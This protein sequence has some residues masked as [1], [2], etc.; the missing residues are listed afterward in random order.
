MFLPRKMRIRVIIEPAAFQKI[1]GFMFQCSVDDQT[2][3]YCSMLLVVHYDEEYRFHDS[4]VFPV[5]CC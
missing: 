4:Y 5:F 3:K 1:W 2:L